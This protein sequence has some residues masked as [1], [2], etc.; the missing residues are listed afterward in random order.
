MTIRPS[1]FRSNE[2]TMASNSFQKERDFNTELLHQTQAEH[3]QLRNLLSQNGIEVV[4]FAEEP[5][6]DT[7]DAL[8]P[9]NWFCHLPDGRVFLFPMLAENRR[10]EVRPDLV[11]KLIPNASVTDLRPFT[12]L[13]AFL[14]GT[15]SLIFDHK[16]KQ[17]Y[18][19]LS[20]R[21]HQRVLN[22][23]AEKS[24]YRVFA[25]S[26]QVP[27]GSAI[28]HTNVMMALGESTAIVYL[29]GISSPKERGFLIEQLL[30]T[31]REIL[32]ID[33]QQL[34][35]LAG[36]MLQLSNKSGERFWVASTGAIESL[37]PNQKEQITKDCKILA[38]PIPTIEKFGG[39]GVRCLLAEI[40]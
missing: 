23:F 2:Q 22:E 19:C 36:N 3:D 30:A 20:P 34:L 8:F 39:G 25:F 21:T 40:F 17:A 18:A 4:V 33:Y 12:E 6:A 9:N 15:G 10:K 37:R 29:D 32:A 13:N 35:A 26:A 24:G 28:Y 38:V 16:N 1:S 31:G 27:T 7:P 14:E 11:K 5:G